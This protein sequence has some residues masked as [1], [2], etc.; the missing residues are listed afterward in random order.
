MVGDT[1]KSFPRTAERIFS[2]HQPFGWHHCQNFSKQEKAIKF[3]KTL[4]SYKKIT[5]FAP[6]PNS[7][8]FYFGKTN[9]AAFTNGAHKA[10]LAVPANEAKAMAYL[11][12][13]ADEN[14]ETTGVST[15]EH[16]AWNT[17]QYYSIDGRRLQGTPTSKGIYIVNGRKLVVK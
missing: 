16:G 14:G 9:G 10:Y 12:R 4:A 2:Y 3:K 6:S 7:V 5:T 8:G 17:E 11:F 1:K 13:E 15:F